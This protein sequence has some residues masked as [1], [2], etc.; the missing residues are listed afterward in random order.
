MQNFLPDP[1]WTEELKRCPVCGYSREGLPALAAC[2]ECSSAPPGKAFVVYGVPKGIVGAS[3]RF[4]LIAIGLTVFLLI[5]IQFWPFII[6]LFGVVGFF[7]LLVLG[8]VAGVIMIITGRGKQSG[9]TRFVF[10]SGGAYYE[11]IT[12]NIGAKMTMERFLRWTG[13]EWV[14]IDRVGPYWRKLRIDLGPSSSLLEAG[15][16][17]P[18]EAEAAVR[19][20]IEESILAAVPVA[21]VNQPAYPSARMNSTRAT[22]TTNDSTA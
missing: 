7:V 13:A 2:P 1:C 5:L 20:A 4:T 16:R 3:R 19:L 8:L 11:P 9:K 14:T 18:D 6:L 15:I 10:V 21:D 22:T 17:C 12:E